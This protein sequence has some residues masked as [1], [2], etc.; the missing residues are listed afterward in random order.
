MLT[1][2][3]I[4]ALCSNYGLGTIAQIDLA[5]RGIENLNYF[6][7]INNNSTLNSYV[8]TVIKT[9]SYTGDS[10][11]QKMQLLKQLEVAVPSPQ[12]D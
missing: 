8:L 6:I 1:N 4:S 5:T 10:Y 3:I 11:F 7:D 9:P 2:E 12:K